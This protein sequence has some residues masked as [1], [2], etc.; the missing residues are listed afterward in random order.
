MFRIISNHTEL[1]AGSHFVAI[2]ADIDPGQLIAIETSAGVFVGRY[3]PDIIGAAW[4]IQPHHAIKLND[5]YRTL[6]RVV[7]FDAGK[8]HLN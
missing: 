1:A 8:T 2:P 5:S 4:L 7:E 6:G 3:Y